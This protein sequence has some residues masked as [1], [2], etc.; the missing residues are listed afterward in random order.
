M[1]L[2]TASVFY[3]SPNGKEHG[4]PRIEGLQF[5]DTFGGRQQFLR[6]ATERV[7][8]GAGYE[9][10]SAG[11]GEQALASARQHLFALILLDIMLPK[12]AV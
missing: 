2:A 1:K 4:S 11:D 5:E 8:T 6:V 7:L 3:I 12:R 9:V 10:I